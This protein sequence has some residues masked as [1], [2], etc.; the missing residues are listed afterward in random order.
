[1]KRDEN[2]KE[3]KKKCHAVIEI[4]THD[5]SIVLLLYEVCL[6]DKIYITSS[7]I[8]LKCHSFI[9]L[10]RFTCAFYVTMHETKRQNL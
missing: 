6:F 5:M 8:V 2:T 9:I 10:S 4:Y 7:C 1:M 3:K